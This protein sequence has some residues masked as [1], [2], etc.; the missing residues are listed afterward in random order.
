MIINHNML[1]S[2]SYRQLGINNANQAKSTEKLASGLRI[3]RAG[4]DAAGLAIS[5]KMRAQVRG[6][7]QASRNSQ[8]GISM[9]QTA[10][11]ALAETHSILQ[12]MRELATQSANDTNVGVDREEIQKEMNQL[13]SEI[14]RIGNTTEFNTQKLLNG[15]KGTA[16]TGDLTVNTTAYAATG[17]VG[18][19]TLDMTGGA[20]T[21]KVSNL[22]T[23]TQSVKAGTVE[24]G[25]VQTQTAS[26]LAATAGTIGSPLTEVTAST[27]AGTADINKAVSQAGTNAATP[28]TGAVTVAQTTSGADGNTVAFTV[29]FTSAFA[30]KTSGDTTS[31][32]I[33]GNEY[34]FAIGATDAD[35]RNNLMTALKADAA[36]AAGGTMTGIDI[37]GITAGAGAS[38]V[39]TANAANTQIDIGAFTTT[40]ATDATAVQGAILT[41]GEAAV[42]TYE[43]K[44]NFTAGDTIDI[45]GQTFT[46]TTG[47]PGG[48][49]EFQVGADTKTTRDNLVAALQAHASIGNTGAGSYTVTAGSPDWGAGDDN[50]ITITAKSA[51][52]DANSADYDGNV[53]AN[54]T[55]AVKGEYKFEIASNFEVGQKVTVAGQEFE[56]RDS[57]GA[58]DA[59]GFKLG[60]DINATA[61]NL[62]AAINANG[63]LTGKF[64]ATNLQASTGLDTDKDTIVL[65]EKVASGD[66][67]AN[68]VGA[69]ITVTNQAAV[70]GVYNF[71]VTK[72]FSV[73][74]S[75]DIGG[76]KYTATA[77]GSGANEFQVGADTA[78][79][80]VNLAA[81]ITADPTSKFNAAQGDS[82]F[83]TG[84]RVVLTEKVASGTDLASVTGG[85]VADVKGVSE[86]RIT[87]NLATGDVL[88]FAGKMLLA[89]GANASAGLTGDFGAGANTTETATNIKNAINN[90]TATSSQALQDLKAKYDV[91]TTG[92]KLTFTEKTASGTDLANNATNLSIA[93]NADGRADGAPIKQSYDITTQA[94]DAGSKVKIGAAE[95]TLAN[96]GTAAMVAQELKDQITNA[97]ASSTQELQDLKANYDVTVAGD[98]L[99]L[100]KKTAGA[101]TAIGANFETTEYKGFTA[102]L[103]IGAN[104]GQTMALS[105]N[106]M[107]ATALKVSGDV[108]EGG[109]EV[110]AKDGAKATYV[111]TANVT[112]GSNDN[113]TE[114]ALDVSSNEK[115]T[116]AISVINDAIESVSA[117]R[118]KLG[119]YQN[120]LEHTIN[121]LST[122]SENLTAAESRVRDTDMAKTVMDNTKN[123]ILAQAAQAMLAQANQ[124]PQQVLQLLR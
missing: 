11:G 108:V 63:T 121:N 111:S 71:D 22:A 48:A 34:S 92:D 115:A 40:V 85:S 101:E 124:A 106:D 99:T 24:L 25:A 109:T 68:V 94:L 110:T 79:S 2:N 102:S 35:S 112:N 15:G 83:F 95:I 32:S 84:N 27:K 14:N 81:K 29:D 21:G 10:E 3:N 30:G 64:T 59:T 12:R 100:T 36:D 31:V 49:N 47:A 103:Q 1:A 87:D 66:T 93:K 60:A 61:T 23:T 123:G 75:V 51:G 76:K 69:N 45:G 13:T 16:K 82:T 53:V 105:V 37:A 116:A 117:E 114:F 122:S 88:Q 8:D 5:E 38:I 28:F 80:V 41:G 65:Q 90:A 6:L 70:Q 118:S 113:E 73:G 7:D 119:A 39:F 62:L 104:T 44:T 120:R 9:I 96:K 33:G 89:G 77:A 72:N 86:F 78:A 98:K 20:A 18:T 50:S 55:A 26:K 56:V 91:T 67:M 46:A 107:R 57:S 52:L 4:D 58:N 97:D 54:Q 43:L 74:D 19:D 42:Y 17:K